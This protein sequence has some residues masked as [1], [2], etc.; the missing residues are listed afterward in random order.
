MKVQLVLM[1]VISVNSRS[2][3]ISPSNCGVTTDRIFSVTPLNG[4]PSKSPC[5][6]AC[7]EEAPDASA[8]PA[9]A[10]FRNC[11]RVKGM[12]RLRGYKNED[13]L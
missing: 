6:A 7:T 13:S 10:V 11:R 5:G 4:L 1:P 8:A 2:R 9:V 3:S 12:G